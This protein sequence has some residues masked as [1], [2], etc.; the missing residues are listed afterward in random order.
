M[1]RN[2][3]PPTGWLAFELNV[4]R[5]LKFASAALPIS[6]EPNL[7]AF[8]KRWNVRVLSN[9][10]LESAHVKAV[11]AIQNNGE[12]LT[13]EDVALILE[14][15]YQPR[16]KLQNQSLKNW[17]NETDAWWFDNIRQNIERLSS[18]FKQAAALTIAMQTGD[19][20]LSFDEETREF[21]Q[22]LS[23]VYR[24]LR[25]VLPETFDNRQENICLNKNASD[26][27]AENHA[28]LMFLRLPP[29]RRQRLRESLG[30][31]AWREEFVRVSD[32]FWDAAERGQA[33][34]LGGL[35]ETKTQ[36][37]Q[38]LEEVLRTASNVKTWAI[39]HAE[40]GFITTQD[41]VELVGRVRRVDTIFTKDFSELTGTKAVIVTA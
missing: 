11:A 4:L 39:A 9:D 21:R 15:A 28:D 25:S 5:R 32:D 14:D 29:V 1:N 2:Y 7:G 6:A 34:R 19:Y 35:I 20:L 31:S 38:L 36:Y 30:K 10:T 27:I 24:R 26:F 33:N 8:L 12:K 17:F 23:N 18:P 13:D 37:L 41:I 16:Y 40:D 3:L 22:P